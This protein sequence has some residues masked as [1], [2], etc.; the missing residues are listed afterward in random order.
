MDTLLKNASKVSALSIMLCGILMSGQ[1]FAAWGNDSPWSK[2][3]AELNRL[4]ALE[5][6]VIDTPVVQ[7]AF[8][9]IAEPIP[10]V[11]LAEP[12]PMSDPMQMPDVIVSAIEPDPVPVED[13]IAD[14]G[15]AALPG[16]HFAVQVYASSSTDNLDRYKT[17]NGLDD[18][19]SVK[20]ERN[21]APIYVLISLHEDRN[22]ADEAASNLEQI[23]GSK[24]WIRTVGSLQAVM[25]Q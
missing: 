16:T 13:V 22:S 17:S 20:T 15:I 3:H 19:T 9:H 21:G 6:A 14:E 7:P 23:I 11:A 18:L 24:P 5:E 10:A 25:M 4:A 8:R 2:K 1:A 12:V